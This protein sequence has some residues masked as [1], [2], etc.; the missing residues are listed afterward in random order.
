[1]RPVKICGEE[2]LELNQRVQRFRVTQY[3]FSRCAREF[4]AAGKSRQE[5]LDSADCGILETCW[6]MAIIPC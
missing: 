6:L 2:I 5:Q 3:R 1:M 4:P